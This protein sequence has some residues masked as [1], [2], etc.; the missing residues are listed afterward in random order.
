MASPRISGR[1]MRALARAA[2][3]GSGAALVYS[4]VRTDLRLD[5]LAALPAEMFGDVPLDNRP[6]AG[7]PPR[8]AADA[9]LPLPAPP[10]SATSATLGEAY[11][12]GATT[13]REIVARAID[14]THVLASRRPSVGPLLD[15]RED[16]ARR[17]ADASA[18]RWRKGEPLG[19]LDGIPLVVKEETA[20]AGL[21]RR[22][23]SDLTDPT[24]AA[25]D[26]TCVARLRAAGAVVIGTTPMT[27][28]GM[29]PLGYNPKR[30]MPRNPHA[31][32]RVAGGSSTGSAVAVAAGVVPFAIAAD[33]GGSIRIPAALCGVFGLKPTW[34]R[35]SR[36]GDFFDGTVNHLGPIASSTLDLARFLDATCGADPEDDQTAL[37]PPAAPSAFAAALSRGVRGL[38]IGVQASEWEEASSEVAKAGREALASLEAEGAV[39]VDLRMERARW[40]APVGYLTI[41][42][43]ALSS[44]WPLIREGKTFNPDLALSHATLSRVPGAELL[45]A[46]RLRGAL[47][48]EVAAAFGTVDLIALPTTVTT[49]TRATDGEHAGGFV[50]ARALDAMCRYTFLGNLTGLPAATAPVGVDANRLPIGLQLVG[51]AWDEATVLA[52]VAHLERLGVARVCR[53]AASVG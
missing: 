13:P 44:H 43:E 19:P 24:P 48:R 2:S 20:V 51:D 15:A 46:A 30:A 18:E 5:A 53:P 10:W 11:R 34:G 8:T 1:T 14:A 31:A 38:R 37:A 29:T 40:A 35:I 7:R 47:R 41:G 4:L 42:I 27:E 49:A 32:D 12:T 9:G 16:A 33:G 26:A 25:R 50:D 23:G 21:P 6:V 36:H 22:A 3:T 39:L 17:E 28:Y 45:L 52:A